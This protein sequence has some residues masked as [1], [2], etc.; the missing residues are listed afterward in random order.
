M[1]PYNEMSV[2]VHNGVYDTKSDPVK[3]NSDYLSERQRVETQFEQDIYKHYGINPVD[4]HWQEV[5]RYAWREGHPSGYM[6]VLGIFDDVY[7]LIAPFVLRD[8]ALSKIKRLEQDRLAGKFGSKDC[9][10]H[11]HSRHAQQ[12]L[13]IITEIENV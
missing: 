4:K 7:D 10:D 12:I 9:K 13:D 11:D 2:L 3:K 6:E 1:N 8:A 5:Y